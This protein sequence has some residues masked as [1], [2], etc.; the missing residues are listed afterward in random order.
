LFSI[1]VFCVFAYY[2]SFSIY[3]CTFPIF[4]LVYQPLA[5]G[6]NPVEENKYYIIYHMVKWEYMVVHLVGHCATSQK[7]A[8]LITDGGGSQ[9]DSSL[10]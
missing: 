1:F 4:V 8:G 2:L 6:G 7:V 3:N 10:T 9:R 5:L